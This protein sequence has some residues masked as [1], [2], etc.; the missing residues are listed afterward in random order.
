MIRRR[1]L[2]A[3]L[4]AVVTWPRFALAQSGGKRPLIGILCNTGRNA[5]VSSIDAFLAGMRDLGRVEGENFEIVSRFSDSDNSKLPALAKELLGQN[6]DL[7]LATDPNSA[8]AAHQ[9]TSSLPIVSVVLTDPIRLGLVASYARPGGNVT[10]ILAAVDGLSGKQVE[11]A[12]ELV[13]GARRIGLLINATNVT[14]TSQRREIEAAAAAKGVEIVPAEVR[15]KADLAAAF[16]TLSSGGA[17]I[18]I[19]LRDGMLIQNAGQVAEQALSSRLPTVFGNREG[20]VAGGLLGYGVNIRANY[21][22]AAYF[23]DRILKGS[24]VEDLPVI[25]STKF[26]LVIN[27]KTAKALGLTIPPTLLARADEV[28]E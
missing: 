14:S 13:P 9:A 21:R 2:I 22:R 3:V 7:I 28:I 11:L 24:R 18:V 25:Q 6:P 8:F 23:V 20:V 4:G 16:Q 26:E 12:L 5:S 19:A 17:Q 15:S 1:D 27:L 10:G